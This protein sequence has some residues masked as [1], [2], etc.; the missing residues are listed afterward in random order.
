MTDAIKPESLGPSA[1]FWANVVT[2]IP[3]P[4]ALAERLFGP[5]EWGYRCPV[6]GGFI[7]DSAPYIA[8]ETLSEKDATIQA[9][10]ARIAELE[11]ALRPF[12][13]DADGWPEKADTDT[14]SLTD[15][16][17]TASAYDVTVGDL[18]RA[19]SL[20]SEVTK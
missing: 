17:G 19:R 6:E 18:R 13:R 5:H 15:P 8:A 14:L 11:G 3:D 4:V 12:A 16:D 1:E 2:T 7:T 10:A 20:L 9:Q